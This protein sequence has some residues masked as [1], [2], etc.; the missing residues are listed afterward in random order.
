MEIAKLKFECSAALTHFAICIC[1]FAICNRSTLVVLVALISAIAASASAAPPKVNYFFP[2]G[3]QRGQTATITASGEFSSWPVQIW[4]DRPGLTATCEKDKGK[5]KVEVAADAAP[6]VYW[7]R[8]ADGEGAAALKPFVVGALPEV[9]ED[10]TNDLPAK[11]Q[12]VDAKGVV[13][14]KLTTSGDLDGCPWDRSKGQTVVASLQGHSLLGS[15]MDCVLQVCELRERSGSAVAGSKTEVEAYVLAQ[16]H[17]A[18]G[19]DPQ[20]DFTAP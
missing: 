16:N 9:L 15:P 7:L 3:A 6:G 5:L 10:E 13:S 2:A 11:P 20:L 8:L 14:G 1:Q 19:L 17:D 4:A 12:A 18:V